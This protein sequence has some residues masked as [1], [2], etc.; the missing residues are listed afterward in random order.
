MS[1]QRQGLVYGLAAYGLWGL[2]PLYWPLLRRH[3]R[4]ATGPLA[5]GRL[6]DPPGV[7]AGEQV[8]QF[9]RTGARLRGFDLVAHQVVVH[10]PVDGAEDAEGGWPVDFQSGQHERQARMGV[11]GV[12]NEQRLLADL[13]DVDELQLT[14]GGHPDTAL[15][16]P[17]EPDGTAVLESD[18]VVV[19]GVRVLQSVVR[20]VVEDVAVLVD[21]YQGGA[22]VHRRRPQHRRQ[23]PPIGVDRAG[24]EGGLRAERQRHRVER[25]VQRAHRAGLGDLA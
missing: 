16:V 22:A 24:D 18:Q 10:R 2:F 12:V 11:L 23:V 9:G 14:L 21:L 20:A 13:S 6:P 7:A 19:A 1:T 4:D 17:A 3:P 25:P 15:A 5:S 8:L